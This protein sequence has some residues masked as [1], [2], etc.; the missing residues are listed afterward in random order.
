MLSFPC[1]TRAP[2]ASGN[3]ANSRTG[4]PSSRSTLI[5]RAPKSVNSVAPYGAAIMLASSRTT[6]PSSGSPALGIGPDF[7]GTDSRRFQTGAPCPSD[8]AAPP[9]TAGVRDMLINAA[10]L[11]DVAPLWVA[12]FDHSVIRDKLRM[13]EHFMTAT[14][15]LR[16]TSWSAAED[17][18]PLEEGLAPH[19][20]EHANQEFHARSGSNSKGMPFQ[21][22]SVNI[23]PSP[24]ARMSASNK[25]GTC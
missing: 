8:G 24:I 21:A 4:S 16:E 11:K 12:D 20:F 7:A 15:Y 19:G 5:T 9:M 23:E 13:L 14:M 10:G 6:T 18:L 25:R 1:V 2:A 17:L 22:G 3:A